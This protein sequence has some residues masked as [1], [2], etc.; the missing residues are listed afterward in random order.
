[1]AKKIEKNR[2]TVI[3]TNTGYG[4]YYGEIEGTV[5]ETDKQIAA[6][7][8]VRVYNCRHISRWYGGTGGVT[9]LAAWGPKPHDDNRI[10]E[11]CDGALITSVM[12]VFEVG[13]AAAKAFDAVKASR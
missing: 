1:M 5:A 11:P 9:S 13:A 4:L 2:R 12:N 8:A 3:V 6:T 10:G 7:K